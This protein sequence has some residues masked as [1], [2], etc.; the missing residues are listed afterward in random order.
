MKKADVLAENA[1][2]LAAY[3]KFLGVTQ[4]EN[5]I[6]SK[7]LRSCSAYVYEN[8]KYYY[9]VSYQT[10]VAFI[11]KENDTLYDV[12]RYVYFYTATSAQHI[13]KFG[14]DYQKT[15]KRITYRDI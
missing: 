11:D 14:H 3:E 7:R 15:N 9:L 8:S 13:S 12:L 1:L 10:C 4:N 2:A 5:D 6:E